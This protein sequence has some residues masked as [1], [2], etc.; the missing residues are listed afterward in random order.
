[1]EAIRTFY[2]V[3]SKGKLL[4][5]GTGRD[6]LIGGLYNSWS[7]GL[8]GVSPADFTKG[9]GFYFDNVDVPSLV[10][11]VNE[12]GIYKVEVTYKKIKY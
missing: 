7:C 3:Y 10:E 4:K 2:A 5:K 12:E 11:A 1:M 6:D 9:E 8:I